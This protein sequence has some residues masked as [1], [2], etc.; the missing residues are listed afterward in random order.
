MTH[1]TGDVREVI[2]RLNREARH[3][4]GNNS[5]ATDV[6]APL[7]RVAAEF[8]EPL[9]TS[10]TEQERV[11]EAENERLTVLAEHAAM[12]TQLRVKLAVQ[13]SEV[14][15]LKAELE[16]RVNECIGLKRH[17][18][19]LTVK[20]VSQPAPSG[21]QQLQGPSIAELCTALRDRI[22]TIERCSDGGN[23]GV[24]CVECGEWSGG[25]HDHCLVV[26][27]RDLLAVLDA[28][29]PAPDA[30]DAP[31]KPNRFDCQNCGQG[32]AVDDEACCRSYGADATPIVDGKPVW[33]PKPSEEVSEDSW[34]ARYEEEYQVV[35]RV[36]KAVKNGAGYPGEELSCIVADY[37][38]RAEQAR[39]GEGSE[40]CQ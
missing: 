30:K 19:E 26:F 33:T 9:T 1:E 38:R 8:L 10:E 16:S 5:Y 11:T 14:E 4:D 40:P 29:P 7:M 2:E 22:G 25:H 35:D 23:K 37:V 12:I 15:R 24:Q 28:L 13:P 39:S 21:W 32:I 34:K 20:L 3:I 6:L 31:A 27:Y 18:S 17:I 36:W